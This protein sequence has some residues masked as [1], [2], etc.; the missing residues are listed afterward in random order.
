MF[1]TWVGSI[2]TMRA[3]RSRIQ[4]AWG[5][6]INIAD[7]FYGGIENYTEYGTSTITT[8]A[9]LHLYST[10]EGTITTNYMAL[11]DRPANTGTITNHYGI[12]LADQSAIG[13]ANNFAIYSAGGKNYFGDNTGI[14]V[15]NPNE[16]LVVN[17]NAIISGTLTTTSTIT[18]ADGLFLPDFD[19]RAISNG[20]WITPTATAYGLDTT[21]EVTITLGTGCT[22]GQPLYLAGDD[23]NTIHI[24]YVNI[25]TTDGAALAFDQYDILDFMCMDNEWLLVSENNL[26]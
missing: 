17:G 10:N 20:D 9:G 19:D 18:I 1:P 14:G 26:Q 3:N 5:G 11:I 16:K 24:N 25:R 4:N 15:T 23:A 7:V 22:D 6:S 13:T 2:G 8:G 12:Y 21:G